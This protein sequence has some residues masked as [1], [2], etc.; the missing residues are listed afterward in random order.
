MF[1]SRGP[2]AYMLSAAVWSY[3]VLLLC[4]IVIVC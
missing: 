1:A 3:E 4:R 2:L